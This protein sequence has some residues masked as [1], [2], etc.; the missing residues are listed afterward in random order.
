[1]QPTPLLL[2]A[3]EGGRVSLEGVSAGRA[4]PRDCKALAGA[5]YTQSGSYEPTLQGKQRTLGGVP[6]TLA[7]L[8]LERILDWTILRVRG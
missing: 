2:S 1:M 8:A 5:F 7:A 6:K 3:E 4:P